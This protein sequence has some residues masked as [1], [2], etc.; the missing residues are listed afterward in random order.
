MT[1]KPL[2]GG[3]VVGS[4]VG[5]SSSKSSPSNQAEAGRGKGIVKDLLEEEKK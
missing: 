1:S 2:T 5:G 3:I 4:T